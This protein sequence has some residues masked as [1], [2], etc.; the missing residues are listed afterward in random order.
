MN[1]FI[2]LLVLSWLALSGCARNAEVYSMRF[3]SKSG[4]E[5]ASGTLSL[6]DPLPAE[7]KTHG[8][9]RLELRQVART[10]KEV[11]W[12]YRLFELKKKG[13]VEWTVDPKSTEDAP[14]RL[15]FMPGVADANIFA[16]AGP[17]KDGVSR[18][19]WAYSVLSGGA[20]GGSFELAKK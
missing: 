1:R 11:D 3:A 20:D 2:S 19:T 5:L 10:Q 9:Y 16:S 14:Q 12:F 13:E 18:G 6:R 8:K 7:G 15:N 4:E 17:S